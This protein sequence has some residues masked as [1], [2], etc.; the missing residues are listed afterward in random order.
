M[1]FRVVG[2]S[3][4]MVVVRGLNIFPTMVAA[5]INEFPELSGDYR[6]VLSERP[7]YDVLPVQV[8]LKKGR[9]ATQELAEK[10]GRAL[11]SKLG[12]TATVTVLPAASFPVTEG[13][14]K[15]VVRKLT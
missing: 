12:A 15:R 4:D 14:T 5:V 11:K 10:V 2:R 9:S 8:E 1:R 6:I 3:D 13:K 7:P